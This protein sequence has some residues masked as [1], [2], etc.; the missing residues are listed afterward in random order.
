MSNLYRKS[1]QFFLKIAMEEAKQAFLEGEV[2]VGAVVVLNGKIIAQGRNRMEQNQDASAHAEMEAMSKAR[3]IVAE[4][5]LLGATLYSTLEP[6]P[7]CAGTAL[8][9][10]LKQIVFGAYDENWG[11]CGTIY[12]IPQ[13]KKLNHRIELI[14]G[15][16]EAECRELL[17]RFFENRR[18]KN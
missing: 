2:P 11:A 1:H 12:N 17:K 8:L 13:E 15:I 4:K 9:F 16:M 7:M 14:G 6:C 3:K 18:A 10:R 5:M